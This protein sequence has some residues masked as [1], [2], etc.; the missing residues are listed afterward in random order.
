MLNAIL[1][2]NDDDPELE[3]DPELPKLP[4]PKPAEPP[5]LYPPEPPPLEPPEE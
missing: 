2:P 4:E 3:L 5:E 1:P